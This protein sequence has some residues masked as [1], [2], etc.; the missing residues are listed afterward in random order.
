VERAYPKLV[1]YHKLD[2]AGHFP[3]WEQPELF[4]REIRA[5]FAPLRSGVTEKN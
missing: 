1:Y 4:T 5:A 3:A 2:K